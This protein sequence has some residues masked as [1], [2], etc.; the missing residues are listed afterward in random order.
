M[1]TKKTKK[2]KKSFGPWAV[3]SL[4]RESQAR[5]VPPHIPQHIAINAA[6]HEP[7]GIAAA[8][9]ISEFHAVGIVRV[10]GNFHPVNAVPLAVLCARETEGQT[11]APVSVV[12]ESHEVACP[13]ERCNLPK[14]CTGRAQL[15]CNII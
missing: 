3:P 2:V 6:H 12:T 11:A 14:S 1:S 7:D 15:I 4:K 8:V 9:D 5:I 10:K 13:R